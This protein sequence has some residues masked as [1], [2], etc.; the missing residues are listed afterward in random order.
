MTPPTPERAALASGGVISARRRLR[1]TGRGGG[2]GGGG[3]G[4]SLCHGA[5]CGDGGARAAMEYLIGI[6]GPDY[7]LVAADTVAASSIVQMKHGERP[8]PRGA[9]SPATAPGRGRGAG[10]VSSDLLGAGPAGSPG[11]AGP[12]LGGQG[13]PGLRS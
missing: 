4:A 2:G 13:V 5:A 12:A 9:S 6:Q 1:A 10:G 8:G 11:R 7:I 3:G